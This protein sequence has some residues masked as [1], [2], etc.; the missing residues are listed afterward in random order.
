MSIKSSCGEYTYKVNITTVDG[1]K[2]ISFIDISNNA[3]TP[4]WE[5]KSIL[6]GDKYS[7]PV[8]DTLSVDFGAGWTLVG[9]RSQLDTLRVHYPK[10]IL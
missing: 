6:Y 8:D 4:S 3:V 1:V 9:L 7:N 5:L 10:N 2:M